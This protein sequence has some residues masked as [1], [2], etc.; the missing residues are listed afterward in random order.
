[1]QQGLLCRGAGQ[2]GPRPGGGVSWDHGGL[3]V[4]FLA[5][6]TGCA[7]LGPE[8]LSCPLPLPI[9]GICG[10]CP[11]PGQGSLGAGSSIPGSTTLS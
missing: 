2:K 1:M 6:T 5:G 11:V 10:P 7:K 9:W 8:G 4:L 3:W